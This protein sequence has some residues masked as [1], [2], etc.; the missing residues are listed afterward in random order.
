MNLAEA[1]E[2]MARLSR[3][4]DAGLAAMRDQA[5]ELAE[6]ENVYRKAKAQAWLVAPTD[7]TGTKPAEREWIA[8]A[9]EAWV[10]SHTADERRRRD[11]AEG[12][13]RA[14]YQAVRARQT[15]VSALQTLV[16]AWQQEAKFALVGV[17][18]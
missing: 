3:L 15:Q 2:E 17:D 7:P 10:N 16:N 11:L 5:Q 13:A 4:L 8:A 1:A 9:R 14:A 12:M 18:R 6:S